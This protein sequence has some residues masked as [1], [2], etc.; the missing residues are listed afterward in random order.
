MKK[1][2]ARDFEDLLQCSIPVFEG[3][4]PDKTHNRKLMTLL[5]RTAEWHALAKLRM[6]TEDTLNYLETITQQLGKLMREFRDLSD[7][8]FKPF[9]TEREVQAR[10]RRQQQTAGG[11]G[12][13]HIQG[14]QRKSLNLFTYKWHALPD[15]V[16]FIRWF[17]TTDGISTQVGE[18]A[19][20]VVKKLYSLGNKKKDPKQIGRRLRRIDWSK[21]VFDRHGIHTKRRQQQRVLNTENA[22]ELLAAHH[23]IGRQSKHKYDIGSFVQKYRDDPAAKNF[24]PK[25]QDHLLGRLLNLDFD[26]DT[27]ESF[28]DQDRNH[29][30]LKGGQFVSLKTC[31]INYTTYDVRRDQDTINPRNHADVM[32]LSGEDEPGAHPY[33]YAR[34]L[35]IYRAT[36]ISSHPQANTTR[37]GP[38]DMEFLWVRWFGIDPEHRSGSHYARLP[39]VGFVD[40]SDPF[41]FGFLDPAR[42]IRGCHLMPAFM[43]RR[44]NGLLSTT[45]PTIARKP[46]E[47]DDWTHFY[48]GIFVDRDMFM[49]YF[50]GGGVGHVANRKFFTDSNNADSDVGQDDEEFSN[51][52]IEETGSDDRNENDSDGAWEDVDSDVEDAEVDSSND[53][54]EDWRWDDG[55]ASL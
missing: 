1:L 44:T 37:T 23:Q 22:A 39:K 34:V 20:R 14:R 32:M 27:H 51:D 6:H 38:Q 31:R 8:D 25:L 35:G 9:E 53:D 36:V 28:T 15:Y 4:L 52:G 46:G 29:I 12:S 10:N 50:P 26:G 16:P 19:H 48:V 42:V 49:R 54:G 41:A 7:S 2:A 47:T 30:R 21:R 43:D 3:L 18:L 24:W 17:G 40:E 45:N 11:S 5:Y 55:Y 13:N 33:W